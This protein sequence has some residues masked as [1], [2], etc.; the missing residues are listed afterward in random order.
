MTIRYRT[1][2]PD[3]TL[4]RIGEAFRPYAEAHAEADIELYRRNNVSVRVRI[5][6]PDFAGKSRARREEEVW[7]LLDQL[8]DD[9]VAD[10]TML[11][12]L[13]PEEKEESLASFEFD[14][15]SPSLI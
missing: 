10:V 1:K 13:T 4:K 9:V 2:R 5:I 15:P 14:H 6:D 7:P 12:L 11:V 8:P 3:R